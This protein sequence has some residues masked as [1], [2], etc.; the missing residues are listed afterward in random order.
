MND[1][2]VRNE[3]RIGAAG[4]VTILAALAAAQDFR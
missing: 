3:T 4:N 2:G 1:L